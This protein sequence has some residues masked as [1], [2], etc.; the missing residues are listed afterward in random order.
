MGKTSMQHNR[1]SFLATRLVAFACVVAFCL[2]PPILQAQTNAEETVKAAMTKGEDGMY[3]AYNGVFVKRLPRFGDASAVALTK[4]LADKPMADADIPA[5]LIILRDSFDSPVS[6]EVAAERKPRTTLY[7]LRSLSWM[8][9]E[10]KTRA[11]IDETTAYV[12]SQYADYLENHP[13]Q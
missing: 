7:V 13:S 6:I 8:T 9:K 3:S 2:G 11:L 1:Q 10:P 4:L 5:I 12:K